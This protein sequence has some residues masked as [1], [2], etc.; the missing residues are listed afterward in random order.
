MTNT[1]AAR[2]YI[3]RVTRHDEREFIALM[4]ESIDLHE[5]WISPPTN[6]AL[7]RAYLRR[8]NR[9][10]HEG[11][12]S[13][14][15]ASDEIIGAININNIVRGSFQSASLGYYVGARHQ[16]MGYMSEGLNL[17]LRF[18]CQT[19]GLHRLEANI[20]PDNARSQQLVERCGFVKE[21]IS[22]DFLFING[23]WRDHIRWCYVD[24]RQTLR[25]ETGPIEANKGEAHK[26]GANNIVQGFQR[27]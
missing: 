15:R 19:L 26:S 3:R 18:A 7:F 9:E 25:H 8:V 10:D 23:A 6:A 4:R 24:P 1:E 13:C 21:G 14:L 16:G 22:K 27:G 12:V 17:L 5:P 20:Q 2:V 11:F